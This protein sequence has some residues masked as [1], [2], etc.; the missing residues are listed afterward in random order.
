MLDH[1]AL[2]RARQPYLDLPRVVL[3][4]Q[5]ADEI[6]DV[7]THQSRVELPEREP[8]FLEQQ[9]YMNGIVYGQ[10]RPHRPLVVAQV[11]RHRI[12]IRCAPR[13]GRFLYLWRED[14]G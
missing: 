1:T 7:E 4:R 13:P 8:A 2:T 5:H 9:I 3:T 6:A 11:R 10:K 12:F 14:C